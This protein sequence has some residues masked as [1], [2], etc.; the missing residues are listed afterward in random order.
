[1]RSSLGSALP[2]APAATSAAV[3][4]VMQANRGRDT[5]PE[6]ALRSELHRRGLRFRKSWSPP[7]LRSRGDVAF[8]ARRVIVFID[9]CFWHRCPEHGVQPATNSS[10]WKAKLDR[11]VA[12]DR[13]NDESL[14]K[15]GWTVV[16]VWEHE[17]AQSAA[18]RIETLIRAK[19]MPDRRRE[20]S[21]VLA[22]LR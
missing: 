7:G 20:N 1:M 16:R 17:P 14:A 6:V 9:G 10:Y 5:K 11:N 8:P 2:P 4:R 21:N 19:T 3:R 22:R 15:A 18:D 13:R 12:R